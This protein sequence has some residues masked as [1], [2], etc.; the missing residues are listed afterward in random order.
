MNECVYKSRLRRVRENAFDKNGKSELKDC[1]KSLYP[2]IPKECPFLY[3]QKV[4]S[5]IVGGGAVL[6]LFDLS[7]ALFTPFKLETLILHSYASL[8]L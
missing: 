7:S 6:H 5:G 8:L 1:P 4:A 3:S 2:T